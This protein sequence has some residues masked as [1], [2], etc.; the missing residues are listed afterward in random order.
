MGMDPNQ[1]SQGLS[2]VLPNL[3][4]QMTPAGQVPEDHHSIIA[5]GLQALLKRGLAR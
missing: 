3:V 5:D 2:Q 4:N 1:V